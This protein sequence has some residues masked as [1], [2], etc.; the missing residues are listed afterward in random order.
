VPREYPL[1]P[2]STLTGFYARQGT[3]RGGSGRHVRI[4]QQPNAAA[5]Q[6][7]LARAGGSACPSDRAVRLGIV[8]VR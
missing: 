3:L 6:L 4:I 1:A 5:E 7:V 8:R 2:D